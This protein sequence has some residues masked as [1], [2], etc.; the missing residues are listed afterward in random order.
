MHDF[1]NYVKAVM[2]E[3]DGTPSSKRWI[4]LLCTVLMAIGYIANLFWGF[5]VE[6]FMFDSIMW[7]VMCGMGVTGVEKFASFT[8]KDN[9][10]SE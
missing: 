9:T 2:S 5:K 3:H 10:N 1:I 8:K 7:V 4:V 6:Q